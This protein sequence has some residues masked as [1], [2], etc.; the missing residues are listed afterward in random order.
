MEKRL[1]LGFNPKQF[2]VIRIDGSENDRGAEVWSA[3]SCLP[4]GCNFL[5]SKTTSWVG[6][7]FLSANTLLSIRCMR[8]DL[9]P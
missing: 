4:E 7:R 8:G 3:L 9:R 1:V 6:L 2:L 5:N